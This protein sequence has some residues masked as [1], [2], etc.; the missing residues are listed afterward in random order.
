MTAPL[1]EA[2]LHLDAASRW[3]TAEKMLA[4]ET[5]PHYFVSKGLAPCAVEG[6]A[7]RASLLGRVV[8]TML[9]GN[10]PY[11]ADS[12]SRITSKERYLNAAL[13]EGY[14]NAIARYG[15]S[16]LGRMSV[17]G[18]RKEDQRDFLGFVTQAAIN[19]EFIYGYGFQREYRRNGACRDVHLPGFNVRRALGGTSLSQVPIAIVGAG[20]SGL[21]SAAYLSSLGFQNLTLFDQRGRQNGIW[22][23][24]NVKGGSKNNPVALTYSDVY[25]GSAY[26]SYRILGSGE[27]ID[28]YLSEISEKYLGR[29]A[30]RKARVTGILP[31]DLHHQLSFEEGGKEE[32]ADFP[33]VIYAPGIGSPREPNDPARMTTPHRLGEV[34]IRWQQIL[35]PQAIKTMGNKVVVLGMGNSGAEMVYQLQELEHLG[36]DYRW[37]THRSFDSIQAPDRSVDGKPIYR[38]LS[39][40]HLTALAGDLYHI[41]DLFRR[42]REAGRIVTEV[43]NFH[44][45][46][47]VLTAVDVSGNRIEVPFD[48]LY[49]LFGYRQLASINDAMGLKTLDP[50]TGEIAYD[51]DGEVQRPDYNPATD[52]QRHRVY[53]GYFALGPILRN[54]SNPNAEVIPGIQYQIQLLAATACL[55]MAEKIYGDT[56]TGA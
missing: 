18:G 28:R 19:H 54:D 1:G 14:R 26:S 10:H 3:R 37:L 2:V 55:R 48:R 39:E 41:D 44:H 21:L 6:L 46:N 25:V 50:R 35:T 13:V 29:V 16:P 47:Q 9:L 8:D 27:D 15:E 43:R 22:K 51:L 23:Q 20:A 30:L 40:P 34:G 52:A 38:R 31:G 24:L 5:L 32:T 11:S 42:A 49:T 53:P 7:G 56:R 33:I 45:E 12:S 17:Y 4:E 36:V